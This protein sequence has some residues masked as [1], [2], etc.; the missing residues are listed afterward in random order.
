[1]KHGAAALI[2]F[3]L[4]APAAAQSACAALERFAAASRE[5]PPF[6]SIRRALAEDEAVVPGFR[7]R[8]CNA[9]AEGI[10]CDDISFSIRNFDARPEPLQCTGVL[11]APLISQVRN[12]RRNLAYFLIQSGLRIDYGFACPGCAGGPHAYFRLGFQGRVRPG[13]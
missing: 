11:R 13:Q 3:F 12:Q 9:D 5:T 7:A 10:A 8:D 4:P 6:H 2:L 1:M